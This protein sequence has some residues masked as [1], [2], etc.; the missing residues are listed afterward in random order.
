MAQDIPVTPNAPSTIPVVG[1]KNERKAFNE[2]FWHYSLAKQDLE[3]RMFRENGFNDSDKQFIGVLSKE[4]PF[5]ARIFDPRLQT[6]VTEKDARLIGG[7]PKGRFVAREGSDEVGALINNELFNFQWEDIS[8]VGLPMLVRWQLMSQQTRRYG[9]AFGVCK[10]L[11][12]ERKGKT[13]FDGPDFKI[14]YGRDALPNPA[15][16]EIKDWFQYREWM[17]LNDLK[18]QNDVSS[19]KSL[20]INLD[21]LQSRMEEEFPVKGERRDTAYNIP[22]KTLRGLQDRMGADPVFRIFEIVHE[23]REERWITFAP[24]YGVVIRN[25][26]NPYDHGEIPVVMLRYN[27]VP[28]D[29]YGL[30]EMETGASVQKAINALLCADIDAITTD[31]YPPL[32]INPTGVRMHTIEFK[33]DARWLMNR[34]GQDV[35]RMQTSTPGVREFVDAY[36]LMVASLNNS[37]GETTAGFS[38]VNPLGQEKTATEVRDTAITRSVRDNFNQIMLAEA[39]KKQAYFWL[40]M[41]KQYLFKSPKG[42][43]KIIRIVGREAV[44]FFQGLGMDQFGDNGPKY[45]VALPNG[46]QVPQ[47]EPSLGGQEGN[48]YV[49]KQDIDGLYDFIP[50]VESMQVASE[51]Q[52]ESKLNIALQLLTNQT[53]VAEM[54][55]EGKRPKVTELLIKLLETTRVIKNAESFFENIPQDQQAQGQQA[56]NVPSESINFKDLPAEGQIQ[57]A[58]QAGIQLSNAPGPQVSGQQGGIPT[59]GQQVIAGGLPTPQTNNVPVN[60]LTQMP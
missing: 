28:D 53:I 3:S 24:R 39:L 46:T 19:S 33:P 27:P 35:Q 30:S 41:N 22:V 56:Q 29:L 5:Q 7:K 16:A 31:L 9:A 10:W 54:A 18:N 48:L 50:D 15:Y 12:K 1:T 2:V 32:M 57:M 6:I 38:Q 51:Q 13:V 34:P 25:I 45:P 43:M 11:Y 20:W 4:W 55:A 8:R 37:L 47:F 60:P 36:S 44:N 17:T 42:K 59:N 21:Q 49:T 58:Q 40:E 26:P 14:V 52:M 23:L